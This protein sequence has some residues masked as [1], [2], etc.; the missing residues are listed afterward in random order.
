MGRVRVRGLFG[1]GVGAV[2]DFR[3]GGPPRSVLPGTYLG[4][5]KPLKLLTLRV[6]V[7]DRE[8]EGFSVPDPAVIESVFHPM[9]HRK[10]EVVSAEDA[11]SGWCLSVS[12]VD[13][14]GEA[15]LSEYD[16]PA[17]MWRDA[18]DALVAGRTVRL[19]RI[20]GGAA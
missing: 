8:A 9:C 1:A 12:G 20:N 7:T 19:V 10:L 17:E 16:D 3:P 18:K 2:S 6:T 11:P 4:G 13:D 14:G 5:A 15:R